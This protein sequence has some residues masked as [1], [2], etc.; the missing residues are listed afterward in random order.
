SIKAWGSKGAG[1][2]CELLEQPAPKAQP[3]SCVVR[4]AAVGLNPTDWKHVGSGTHY[5]TMTKATSENPVILGS[6]GS[7]TVEQVPEGSSFQVGQ[8]AWRSARFGACLTR[9][10][11]F[12][13][14]IRTGLVHGLQE[15]RRAGR[16]EG[17]LHGTSARADVHGGVRQYTSGTSDGLSKH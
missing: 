6:E 7:G 12:P 13:P 10:K 11:K 3:G 2:G 9:P 4:V 8:K 5:Y 16:G 14:E 15:L 1:A 17:R